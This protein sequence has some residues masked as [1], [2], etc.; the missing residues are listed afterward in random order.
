MRRVSAEAVQPTYRAPSTPA[1]SASCVL[2][3]ERD[4]A[5]LLLKALAILGVVFHHLQNRRLDPQASVWVG[6]LIHAFDFCVLLFLA[7]SGFL[8]AASDGR[9][10]R[11]WLAFAHS[12][13][14]R[15]VLPFVALVLAYAGIW[16]LIQRSGLMQLQGRLP[17]GFL[18]KVLFSLWPIE[19]RSV[20]EQLYFLPLL[21]LLSL[22]VHALWRAAGRAGVAVGCGAALLAGIALYPHAHTT[23]FNLGV[24]VW[25]L[26]AYAAGFLLQQRPPA[27]GAWLFGVAFAIALGA[28]LGRDALPRA[29][30][31]VLLCAAKPLPGRNL[32]WLGA[33]GEASGTVFAYHT[34][35]LLQP[36]VIV[37]T[38]LPDWRAQLLGV[39]LA[40]AIAIA[41]TTALHHSLKGTRF[42][43]ALL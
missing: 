38:R 32:G 14:T 43:R 21:F 29:L 16:Q 5:I 39:L 37:M 4:G 2:T 25:G 40:A 41:L 3:S 22:G 26:F 10:P 35:F 18:D 8:H 20:A 27:R 13:V 19:D 6:E 42:E 28:L 1:P 34:P 30:P 11:S 23:G 9:K 15:L 33:V 24:A 36:L 12:R 7:I 31:I 17:S